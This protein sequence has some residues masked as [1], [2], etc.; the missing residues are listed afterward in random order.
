[1]LKIPMANFHSK[2]LLLTFESFKLLLR[3]LWIL[4]NFERHFFNSSESDYKWILTG[5]NKLSWW[6]DIRPKR[7]TKVSLLMSRFKMLQRVWL[8]KNYIKWEKKRKKYR[9]CV[10]GEAFLHYLWSDMW[11]W[12]VYYNGIEHSQVSYVFYL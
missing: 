7:E 10:G 4:T 8:C 9:G 12:L 11:Y 1:M 6:N 2:K 3:L 5:K